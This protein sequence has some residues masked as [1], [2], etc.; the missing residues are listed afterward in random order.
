MCFARI[1][2]CFDWSVV[3]SINAGLGLCCCVEL[4]L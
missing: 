4:D 2:Y 3:E 1:F